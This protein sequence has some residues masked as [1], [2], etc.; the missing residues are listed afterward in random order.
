MLNRYWPA[1]EHGSILITTQDSKLVHR[2]Q[3]EVCLKALQDEEGSRLILQ[4]L[5]DQVSSAQRSAGLARALSKEV[6]GL[7][8]YLF[9]L[10]G[11]MVDSCTPLSDTLN[12]LQ[13]HVSQEWDSATFQ[14]GRPANSA[15]DVSL[16]SLSPSALSVLRTIS[17]LSPDSI[18]ESLLSGKLD[19]SLQFDK[20]SEK[21][22]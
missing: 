12:D 18:S 8:L 10:A 2:A 14:Y 20:Y 19:S 5:P 9:G 13:N 7:P 11:F 22:Q 17:M 6:D 3:S 21:S 15:F 4:Y 1:C 16:K